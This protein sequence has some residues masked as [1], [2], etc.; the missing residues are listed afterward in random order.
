MRW[1][2][3]SGGLAVS[4]A[5]ACGTVVELPPPGDRIPVV[6]GL[7]LADSTTSLFRIVWE[8]NAEQ[9]LDA[10]PVPSDQVH[11]EL[12]GRTGPAARLVPVADSPAFHRAALPIVRGGTYRLAGRLAGR[13][14]TA[15]AT[16]PLRFDV[17]EPTEPL[18]LRADAIG[19]PAFRWG[20]SG[21]AAFYARG[22]RLSP[23]IQ[24]NT[25][26]TAGYLA[27]EPPPP[28][29]TTTALTLYA[30]TREAEAYLFDLVA[31]RSNI[32][33]AFGFLGGGIAVGRTIR[34]Q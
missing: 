4:A 3:W 2:Q 17:M 21:A 12:A 30:I 24:L 10:E 33:G 22:A 5:A 31:P 15:V 1:R 7:L 20:A 25:R 29:T 16:I 32:E 14:V 23:A 13:S 11:L 26:D 8:V 34:W 9:G 27:I 28:G 18:V 6:E 19:R